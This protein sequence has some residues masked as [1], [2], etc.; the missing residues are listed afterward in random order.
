MVP[1]W[2]VE[3]APGVFETQE[4]SMTETIEI[5]M[6]LVAMLIIVLAKVKPSEVV[7][8]QTFMAGIVALLALFGVAWMANTFIEAHIDADRGQ[9]WATG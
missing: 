9:F 6:L 4:L 2:E 7:K 1:S 5:I 8:Q 3:T